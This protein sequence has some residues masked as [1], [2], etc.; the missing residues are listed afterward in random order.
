MHLL[1]SSE[2]TKISVITEQLRDETVDISGYIKGVCKRIKQV[3][4]EIH[5]L[6]PEQGREKRLLAE[7]KILQQKFPNKANRPPLYGV[8]VGIKDIILTDGFE[9]KAGSALPSHLFKGEQA[10][11]VTKLKVAGALIVGKTQ[12]TEFAYFEPAPTRNPHNLAHTPG[13]SSSGSAAGVAAGIMPLSIGTQTIGSITRPAAYCGI[14]GFKPSFGRIENDGVIPFSIS[15]DHL[16][17]F[18]QDISG[19]NTVAQVLCNNWD[20]YKIRNTVQPIIGIVTGNYLQQA[21]AEMIDFFQNQ[22]EHLKQ[23]G[24]SIKKIPAMENIE[25]IN[26]HHKNLNAWEFAQVHSKWLKSFK[27]LYRK[28]TIELIEKGNTISQEQVERAKKEIL[29]FR[30]SLEQLANKHG[31][32]LWLSPATTGEAP[33]GM[34]TGNPIMNLPWTFSGLPT[35]TIPAGKSKNNLPLGLQ[36]AGQFNKDEE[37][38]GFVKNIYK[39]L[40]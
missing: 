7:A 23:A 18:I 3:N 31:I 11:L 19:V 21:D 35:L 12:T 36:F 1:F 13:G 17:F 14:V 6:L 5:A 27:P 8:L 20:S 38:L 4:P 10:S 2:E 22:I 32:N 40:K 9:T 30:N 33:K 37:L 26:Q 15:V 29:T 39:H 25:Q 16:G 34:P 24:F 28:G